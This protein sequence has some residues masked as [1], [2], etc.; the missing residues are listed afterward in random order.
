MKTEDQLSPTQREGLAVL[1]ELLSLAPEI[2]LGQLMAHLGWLGEGH[3][4]HGL[5]DIEDEE[6]LS[7][8]YRHRAELLARLEGME[9]DQQS[10]TI[11]ATL[12]DSAL[13]LTD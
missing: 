11:A 13:S 5:W 10:S 8:M 12:D 4:R 2:R 9:A 6:L 1:A 3:I 7:I